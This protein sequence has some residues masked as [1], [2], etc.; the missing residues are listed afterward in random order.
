M[1]SNFWQWLLTLILWGGAYLLGSVPVGV[2]VA[3]IQGKDLRAEGSGNI[4][5]TNAGRVLG[6][7]WGLVVFALDVAKAAIPVF[8]ARWWLPESHFTAATVAIAAISGHIW[9][10]FLGFRGGKGVATMLGAL[11][12]VNWV[13]ALLVLV[14]WALV[15]Q[16]TRYVSVGS[17]AA[18]FSGGYFIPILGMAPW[19][20]FFAA[21]CACLVIYTHR[22]NLKRLLSGTEARIGSRRAG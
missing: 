22:E 2:L 17:I 12:A 19:Y 6:R 18:V 5:A 7:T 10:V 13:A 4:G 8:L 20:S 11:L 15:T 14:V 9:S 1:P 21:L 16:T 3:K